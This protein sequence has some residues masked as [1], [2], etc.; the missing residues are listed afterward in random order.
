MA[1]PKKIVLG[2]ALANRPLLLF[3]V[4]MILLGAQMFTT[5]LLGEMMIQRDM[6]RGAGYRV[7][8]VLEPRPM[9]YN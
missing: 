4:M 1:Q 2:Y 7:G 8:N 3:G 5:G 9:I 6:D